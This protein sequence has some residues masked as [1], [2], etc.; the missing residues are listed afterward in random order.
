MGRFH[1]W[2][3]TSQVTKFGLVLHRPPFDIFMGSHVAI[4]IHIVFD[5]RIIAY[6]TVTVKYLI[7]SGL[8]Y[9]QDY[10]TGLFS[11]FVGLP[12]GMSHVAAKFCLARANKFQILNT[13]QY[14]ISQ[15]RDA[16]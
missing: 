6:S 9:R 15:I 7:L 5:I 3:G 11:T 16:V 10:C 4:S 12:V 8:Y 2:L 1:Y 13:K 14:Q